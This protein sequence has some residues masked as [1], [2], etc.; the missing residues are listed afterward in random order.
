MVVQREDTTGM[1]TIL[2]EGVYQGQFFKLKSSEI[3][4]G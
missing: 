3:V 1:E 2:L 4:V